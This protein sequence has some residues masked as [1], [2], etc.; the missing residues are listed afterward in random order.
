MAPV[1]RRPDERR[2]LEGR[3]A[4]AEQKQLDDAMR[5]VGPMREEPVVTGRDRKDRE[6][7]PRDPYD[8]RR[9]R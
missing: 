8:E 5:F 4:E 1:I 6:L 7:R 2:V 3:G 9:R